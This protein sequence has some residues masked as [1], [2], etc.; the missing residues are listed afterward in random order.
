MGI[1]PSGIVQAVGYAV[2]A[3]VVAHESR[4]HPPAERKR[5]IPPPNRKPITA[6]P[7][8]DYEVDD[9]VLAHAVELLNEGMDLP[10]VAYSTEIPLPVLERHLAEYRR[11]YGRFLFERALTD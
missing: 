4:M 6:I 1:V 9:D 2:E 8:P 5:G 3:G 11:R 7:Y 10:M